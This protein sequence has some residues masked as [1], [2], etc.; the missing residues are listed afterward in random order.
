M[1][2]LYTK[3]VAASLMIILVSGYIIGANFNKRVDRV[4]EVK[5]TVPVIEYQR[6]KNVGV[7][8]GKININTATKEEIMKL[9]GIGEIFAGRIIERRE[10]VGPYTAIDQLMEIEGIGEGRFNDLED[11][12]TV[13]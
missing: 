12:V 5:E 11:F 8:Y 10:T 2:K 7:I 4:E 13:E 1:N 3:L 9:E 6:P